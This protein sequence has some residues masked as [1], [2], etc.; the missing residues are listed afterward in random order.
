MSIDKNLLVPGAQRV[1]LWT[2]LV[3]LAL[4]AGI[5]IVV[6]LVS[7][8]GD[9]SG[10]AIG[11]MCFVGVHCAGALSLLYWA[12]RRGSLAT[13][14][15]GL[16][17]LGTT[18]TLLVLV[19]WI[20]SGRYHA[21]FMISVMTLLIGLGCALVAV[22]LYESGRARRLAVLSLAF[23]SATALGWI[24]IAWLEPDHF[25]HRYVLRILAVCTWF[26]GA[27]AYSCAQHDWL[28][29]SAPV[30]L[31]HTSTITVWLLAAQLTLA[32]LYEELANEEMTWRLIGV[33]GILAGVLSLSQGVMSRL[34]YAERATVARQGP[35]PVVRLECPRCSSRIESQPGRMRCASCGLKIEIKV[36]GVQCEGCGY[37]LWNIAGK[38]CPECGRAI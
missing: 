36:E 13:L 23:T 7:R 15:I 24:L 25:E 16:P 33:T 37:P 11:T 10:R 35:V 27:L 3:S 12:E 1:L 19:L 14:R 21:A 30:W 32:V 18:L 26:S 38:Q 17:V 8:L 20:P 31:R 4:A 34:R 9:T 22:Q 29:R 6:L 5:T 2:M 28:G